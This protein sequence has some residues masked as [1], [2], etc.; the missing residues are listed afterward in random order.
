MIIFL[1]SFAGRFSS[2]KSHRKLCIFGVLLLLF[3]E[4][5]S[6]SAQTI[7][8]H[9]AAGNLSRIGPDLH[10]PPTISGQPRSQTAQVGSIISLSAHVSGSLPL[11][12]QWQ[13][14]SNDIATATS[15]TFLIPNLVV[16]DFGAYRLVVSNAFGFATSS[17]ALLQLDSDGD[18]LADSWELTYLGS[19]TNYTGLDDYDTDGISN[20]SEFREGTL[21]KSFNSENPRLTIISDHGQVFVTP[22][23]PF[24]SN[25]QTISLLGIPDPGQEFIGYLGSGISSSFYNLKTNPAA[26]KMNDSQMVRAIFGVSITNSLDVTNGWRIDQAGWYGQ[27]NITHDGV[28]A[29]QS[30]RTFFHSE[31]AW[32]ELTNTMSGEGT[33]TFWWK[34]DGTFQ[35]SLIFYLN[36]RARS[37]AIATN[38]DW[39]LRTYYLPSG[40]SRIRWVYQKG[41]NEVSEY[42]GTLYAPA[43]AAWVDEVKFEVWA[44]PLRDTDGDGLPDLWELKYFDNLNS[45]PGDDPDGDQI[46]NLDEYL[47]HTDPTSN[48]SL[49]PRL[50][51]F[52]SGGAV[53]HSPDL[54]KYTY[55]QRVG[56]VAVPDPGNY[57]VIWGGAISGTNI[58]NAVT[59]FRNQSVTAVFGLPLSESL[60]APSLTWERG[61]MIG[62]YGQTNITHDGVDAA[63]SGPVGSRQES[64]METILEGPGALTFMWKVSSRTNADFAMLRIDGTE[65]PGKISGE[66]D[67]N[68]QVYYLSAGTHAV[69]WSFTNYT[70]NFTLTNGCAWVDEVK[71]TTGLF[72]PEIL[73]QPKSL[74]VL[75]GGSAQFKILAAG[76]PSPVYQ[77]YRNGISLDALGTNSTLTLSNVAFAMAGSYHA[78]VRN[79]IQT[80]SSTPVTLTVLP[81]PPVNDNFANRMLLSGSS[82]ATGYDFGA[83]VESNEPQHDHQ[84]LSFS[85]WWRWTAPG[86][87]SYRLIARSSGITS[88]LVADVYTGTSLS[89]LIAQASASQ[90]AISSNGLYAAAVE[91][92]F[93]ATAGTDYTIA[94]GHTFGSGGYFTLQIEPDPSSPGTSFDMVGFNSSGQFGFSFTAPANALYAIESSTDLIAWDPIYNGK[95]PANGIINFVEPAAR[96]DVLRFY[97]VLLQ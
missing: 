55:N 26:L 56:L 35:D 12:Y 44:D 58:T 67:W 42:V 74:T 29:A 80:N 75:Q 9:D 20:L 3:G 87:G 85:V 49:L 65:Q 66:M 70:G 84:V 7:I 31:P 4:S 21:P 59:M 89:S 47:E 77:W 62:W 13:L 92:P 8:F 24:Y 86:A 34:V 17:N 72:G 25:G 32:L 93:D 51:V 57:F 91:V 46:T 37:G 1:H 5:V 79:N 63:Q 88:K 95:V 52:G 16:S 83:T 2:K 48:S 36:D 39:Q 64:W 78:E 41:G 97:R 40:T 54:A 94:L 53:V 38:T 45:N 10:S 73:S 23:L 68:P 19:V 43:D 11:A 18:G 15:D 60:D 82:E 90:T 28:D 33:V 30:A 76:N 27:T 69:R 22:N 6:I 50:T 14:N 61:G 81:I 71:F 96:G